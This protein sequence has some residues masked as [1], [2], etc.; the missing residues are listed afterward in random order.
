MSKKYVLT[1]TSKKVYQ[2]FEKYKLDFTTTLDFLVDM[3]ENIVSKINSENVSD[4]MM[5]LLINK[6]DNLSSM[7]ED[8]NS[9]LSNDLNKLKEDQLKAITEHSKIS[10]LELI[11][12]SLQEQQKLTKEIIP[13]S[14]YN[15]FDDFS[16]NI[17]R[18]I[19][20]FITSQNS[21][22]SDTETK[23]SHILTTK[24][25]ELKQDCE[26]SI[27]SAIDIQSTKAYENIIG[28]VENG[29]LQ[30]LTDVIPKGNLEICE[31]II[32]L[33][34]QLKSLTNKDDIEKKYF[35]FLTIF[36]KD[37][38]EKL[39][40]TDIK[41]AN[42]VSV[43]SVQTKLY[44][45]MNEF[46]DR[47]RQ[48]SSVRG[49]IEENI[50]EETLNNMFGHAEIINNSQLTNACDFKVKRSGRPDILIEVKSYTRNVPKEEVDKFLNDININ[51]CY[52]IILSLHSGISNKEDF[53]IGVVNKNFVVYVHGVAKDMNKIKGA[54]DILDHLHG[55]LKTVSLDTTY[56]MTN[57]ELR[58]ISEAYQNFLRE[59]KNI[60]LCIKEFSA[61]MNASISNLTNGPLE[62]YLQSKMNFTR[63]DGFLCSIC[64]IKVC[65]NNRALRTHEAYCCKKKKNNKEDSVDSS[66]D[67]DE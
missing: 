7:H 4:E 35:E 42:A 2:F 40:D 20:D 15:K 12:R 6:V 53:E 46:L 48:N 28:K 37:I 41:V 50:I 55:K 3:L 22:Q 59:K 34:N 57:E 25:L 47:Y 31:K 18:N 21:K 44:D 13:Q 64:K 32:T 29:T 61:K 45:Q 58:R 51:N 26:N 30:M 11:E 10:M 16:I 5:K 33:S 67:I 17:N 9:K 43:N 39:I 24:I 65:K 36:Q 19:H 60:L 52:G 14:I 1:S 56:D 8:I 38:I 66:C 63:V 54:I 27:K 23:I 49:K 62:E